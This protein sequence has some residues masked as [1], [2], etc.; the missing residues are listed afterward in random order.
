MT[1][2]AT[3][4]TSLLTV[5]AVLIGGFVVFRLVVL[6]Y[7]RV[8][9]IVER[10]TEIRDTLRNLDLEVTMHEK[11]PAAPADEPAERAKCMNENTQALAQRLRKTPAPSS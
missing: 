5:L 2:I 11:K 8:D 9:T 10:L 3:G 4:L 1:D 7:W 6:W